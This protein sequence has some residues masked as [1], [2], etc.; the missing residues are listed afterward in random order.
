MRNGNMEK[1]FRVYNR[2]NTISC[3]FRNEDCYKVIN[4]LTLSVELQDSRFTEVKPSAFNLQHVKFSK[5]RENI[6][7]EEFRN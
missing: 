5:E 7:K 3:V 1:V 4:N 2:F 6:K